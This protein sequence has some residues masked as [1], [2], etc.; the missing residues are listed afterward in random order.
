MLGHSRPQELWT[1][2]LAGSDYICPDMANALG[3]LLLCRSSM[4][5]AL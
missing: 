4:F 1:T 3:V 5:E 2:I